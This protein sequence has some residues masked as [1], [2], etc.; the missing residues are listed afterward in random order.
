[1]TYQLTDVVDGTM[2]TFVHEDPRELDGIENNVDQEDPVL[3]ALRD[4][5]VALAQE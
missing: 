5:V 2:V 3:M 1:M 4:V